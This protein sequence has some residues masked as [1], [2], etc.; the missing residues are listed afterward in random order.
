MRRAQAPQGAGKAL[1][2]E[3]L[4]ADAELGVLEP[5]SGE[6]R[7]WPYDQSTGY[8]HVKG[9]RTKYVHRLILEAHAG[10]P[11]VGICEITGKLAL[12]DHAA[13]SCEN[14]HCCAVAHLSWKTA[15][16]NNAD[17]LRD[18]TDN[19]GEKSV[20]SKL[21]ESDV[22]EIRARYAT[23]LI[24]QRGLAEEYGLA[25]SQISRIVNRERWAHI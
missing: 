19:R 9:F 2:A 1:L 20:L 4:A 13:H 12:K 7:L 22:L 17:K 3:Y 24:S 21:T 5:G 18:G 14:K 15:A 8:G 23:G 16:E 10:Q 6:C 11:Y 25:Q